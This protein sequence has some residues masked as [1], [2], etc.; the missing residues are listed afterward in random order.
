MIAA[1][2][3]EGRLAELEAVIDAGLHTFIEVGLA[4]AEI[5]EQRLYREHYDSFEVYCR[6]RFNFNRQRASQLIKAA[7]V[8]R[9]LDTPPVR[10]SHAEALARLPDAGSRQE[11]HSEVRS[12]KG[13]RATQADYDTAID[14]RVEPKAPKERRSVSSKAEASDSQ[15]IPDEV[16]FPFSNEP[17]D[18]GIDAAVDESVSQDPYHKARNLCRDCDQAIPAGEV[19]HCMDQPDPYDTGDPFD[20]LTPH[21]DGI[22]PPIL[23]DDDLSDEY[24]NLAAALAKERAEAASHPSQEADRPIG[25]PA[26]RTGGRGLAHSIA[27]R[28]FTARPLDAGDLSRALLDFSTAQIV[29]ALTENATVE[30]RK[31]L[32][33]AFG[34]PVQASVPTPPSI[35]DVKR[36]IDAME[37]GVAAVASHAF[38]RLDLD[39]QRKHRDMVV[40][41]VELAETYPE[42][43]AALAGAR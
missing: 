27:A 14:K 32:R 22:S 39:A 19:C 40:S 23:A 15:E 16:A 28:T 9:I 5:R 41:H 33:E 25:E 20:G 36:E 43:A 7:E 29:E 38:R 2:A 35:A 18:L 11:V 4:L 3:T 1:V 8:S 13:N 6:T 31:A 34:G 26:V 42:R 37:T 17:P 24:P 10:A 12:A 30:Q 21:P